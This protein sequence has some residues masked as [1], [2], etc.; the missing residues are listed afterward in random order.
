M[1][2]GCSPLIGIIQTNLVHGEREAEYH[3][4]TENGLST[5]VIE[6]LTVVFVHSVGK[7]KLR[8]FRFCEVFNYPALSFVEG[9]LD[10][11]AKRGIKAFR[12]LGVVSQNC[13]NT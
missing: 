1:L 7:M 6:W 11:P 9:S 4:A 5:K 3:K 12:E 10:N 2:T 8:P 13:S